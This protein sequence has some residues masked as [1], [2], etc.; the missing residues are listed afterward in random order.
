MRFQS[1]P[2][3]YIAPYVIDTGTISARSADTLGLETAWVN[4]P[5]SLQAEFL[6]SFVS[7]TEGSTLNF[8]GYYLAASWFLTGES[9]PYDRATASFTRPSPRQ[10]FSWKKRTWGAFEV[11]CRWSYTNLSDHDVQG[12]GLRILMGGLNWYLQPHIR[13]YLNAGWGRVT[14]T[15]QTGDVGIL[16]V[17]LAVFMQE[18]GDPVDVDT[19]DRPRARDR[20]F[21]GRFLPRVR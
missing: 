15:S 11:A 9:R 3:S 2:E 8:G 5:F 21:P 13:W 17:R 19:G 18:P 4:G 7:P 10:N 14:G 12:G 16:Q 20:V 6:H 1:R